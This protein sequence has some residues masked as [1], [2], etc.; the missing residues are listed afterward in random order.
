MTL[1]S[2]LLA[3]ALAQEAPTPPEVVAAQL[4]TTQAQREQALN[5]HAACE[6][7]NAMLAEENVRLKA[8]LEKLRK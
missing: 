6:A 2:L 4:R 8:E 7:R 5:W 1:L 3:S